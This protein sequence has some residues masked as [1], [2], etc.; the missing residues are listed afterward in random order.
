MPPVGVL[1]RT[2]DI[3]PLQQQ[4][5]Q[6]GF[7]WLEGPREQHP[8]YKAGT[9]FRRINGFKM[10]RYNG[11]GDGA[12]NCNQDKATEVYRPG[13]FVSVNTVS[14]EGLPGDVGGQSVALILDVLEDDIILEG[15]DHGCCRVALHYFWKWGQ[16][17][18]AADLHPAIRPQHRAQ[19]FLQKPITRNQLSADRNWHNALKKEDGTYEEVV[20][21]VNINHVVTV[22]TRAEVEEQYE[23]LDTYEGNF[24][25][26]D[27]ESGSRDN[28]FWYQCYFDHTSY[29]F[30]TVPGA[31]A[32]QPGQLLEKSRLTMADLFCGAGTVS[33]AA[34]A[35]GWSVMYGV[36]SHGACCSS[37]FENMQGGPG[38]LPFNPIHV[39]QQPQVVP[40]KVEDL[41][42]QVAAGTADLPHVEYIHGSPPCQELSRRKKDQLKCFTGAELTAFVSIVKHYRPAFVT[43]EEVSG[44]IW[45][46][47]SEEALRGPLA[48]FPNPPAAEADN[49]A[50]T[51]ADDFTAD[52]DADEDDDTLP[53]DDQSVWGNDD[54]KV[55]FN[56]C[57]LV[58]PQ[59][60]DAGYQVRLCM[61]NSASYGAPQNRLRVL[62]LA[63][64]HGFT[65]P[66]PPVPRYKAPK[67]RRELVT[68]SD[69]N[70]L[71]RDGKLAVP[72]WDVLSL[73][74]DSA[75]PA[76]TPGSNSHEGG[77]TVG[78]QAQHQLVGPAEAPG[79]PSTVLIDSA[80]LLP[81]VTVQEAIGDLPPIMKPHS[82]CRGGQQAEDTGQQQQ[83]QQQQDRA[84]NEPS[85][86]PCATSLAERLSQIHQDSK[87]YLQQ[88]WL[89][90]SK[91]MAWSTPY[92]V[93]GKNDDSRSCVH[94]CEER[95]LTTLERR[96]LMSLPDFLVVRGRHKEVE[97]QV[98]N[99]VP[100]LLA[101]E[102]AASILEAATGTLAPR[103]PELPGPSEDGFG[104]NSLED[105][106]AYE[107]WQQELGRAV[108]K[109]SH[110]A[111]ALRLHAYRASNI[112]GAAPGVDQT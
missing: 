46:M 71:P 107:H 36:D 27:Q 79:A 66:C 29:T 33:V 10:H 87:L 63:A 38:G 81:F 62:L 110:K 21:A 20:S 14:K 100:Y 65:L 80:A 2:D 4:A 42:R 31:V 104:I 106:L 69:C 34:R 23:G 88:L 16:I 1:P 19:I 89:K 50:A 45:H 86:P 74:P 30:D 109:E 108:V 57:L 75:G 97:Q 111:L 35:A 67:P 32:Q 40:A 58:V 5:E 54:G 25:M 55:S 59:L 98:G 94:F 64:R 3:G 96:R 41:A 28:G 73:S 82:P 18:A 43:L 90:G 51:E 95:L 56:A 49:T 24:Q 11:S 85:N 68:S 37:Y 61:V 101:A 78:Q 48:G 76:S 52:D 84:P 102:L 93:M 53:E 12:L 60:L 39:P 92:L 17:H 9:A 7:E 83:Q 47:F 105:M 15:R 44:F 77:G 91:D 112:S 8:D 103:P 99:A 70:F 6:H 72:W 13:A 22:L 26:Q